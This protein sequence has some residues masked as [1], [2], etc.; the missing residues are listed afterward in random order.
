M[1]EVREER[2]MGAEAFDRGPGTG[3]VP[4]AGYHRQ[5]QPETAPAPATPLPAPVTLSSE[6]AREPREPSALFCP[7]C[8]THIT[9][10]L[11]CEPLYS[12]EDTATLLLTNVAALVAL[13]RR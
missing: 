10:L 8:R 2:L 13:M 12:L 9:L 1:P 3:W 5:A 11:P 7:N 6:A 4:G